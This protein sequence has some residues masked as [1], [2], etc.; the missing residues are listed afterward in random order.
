[1]WTC[2][3]VFAGDRF[4]LTNRIV[5]SYGDLLFIS[6]IVQMLDDAENMF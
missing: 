4:I 3:Q 6:A 2:K 5:R 1:M